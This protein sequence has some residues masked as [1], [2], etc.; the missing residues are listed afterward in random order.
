M[1]GG[2]VALDLVNTVDPR[3][4]GR[5]DGNEHLGSPDELLSWA[6]RVALLSADESEQ[7]HAA[8]RATDRGARAHAATLALREAVFVVMLAELGSTDDARAALDV[9]VQTMIAQRISGV[10]LDLGK[11]GEVAGG[12]GYR[13]PQVRQRL[14]TT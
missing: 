2:H 1:V 3:V 8:W 10:M 6:V 9:L 13:E 12:R 5:T 14:V 11:L 4:P 7:V